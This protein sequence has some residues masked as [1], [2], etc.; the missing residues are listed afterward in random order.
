MNI[1]ILWVCLSSNGCLHR[2]KRPIFKKSRIVGIP[3]PSD[4]AE[5]PKE[6]VNQSIER[7]VDKQTFARGHPELSVLRAG[8][9][10]LGTAH[11]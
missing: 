4:T 9:P 5:S 6:Y 1:I 7:Y 3:F 10:Q 11:R 8:Q 2:C